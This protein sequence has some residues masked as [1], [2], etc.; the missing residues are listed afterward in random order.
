MKPGRSARISTG[1]AWWRP[2]EGAGMTRVGG[3]PKRTILVV[4]DDLGI[5]EGLRIALRDRKSVV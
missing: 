4:D 2:G 5:L 3:A 1:P